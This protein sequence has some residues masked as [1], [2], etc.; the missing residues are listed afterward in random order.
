MQDMMASSSVLWPSGLWAEP[1]TTI[2]YIL[3]L[4]ILVTAPKPIIR[5]CV[6]MKAV[7]CA[8]E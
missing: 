2:S 3:I 4:N 5:K 6:K 1:D 7:D 8:I